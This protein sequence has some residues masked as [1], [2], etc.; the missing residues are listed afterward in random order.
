ML[1]SSHEEY[2]MMFEVEEKLW[3]Y[4][5]LHQRVL[6]GIVENFGQNKEIQIS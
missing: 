2:K 1:N 5:T 6:E 3:W 4:Q